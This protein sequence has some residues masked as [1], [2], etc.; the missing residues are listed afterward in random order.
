MLD[1]DRLGAPRI[2]VVEWR[3]DYFAVE[4]SHRLCA[5]FE[6]GLTP[7]LEI[8]ES[9]RHDSE[10]EGFWSSVKQRL[11]HYTWLCDAAGA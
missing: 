3:G 1:M 8:L 7:D 5:A 9:E 4:G 6:L 2:Q 10:D 11:P